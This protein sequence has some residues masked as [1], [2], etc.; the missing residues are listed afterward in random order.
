MTVVTVKL[1]DAIQL[2][3]ENDN[4][5]K[6]E[7]EKELNIYKHSASMPLC[8]EQYIIK[9][10]AEGKSYRDISKKTGYALATV[11]RKVRQYKSKGMIKCNLRPGCRPFIK[12]PELLIA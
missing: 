2:A 1:K 12:I 5:K 10:F 11:G 9:L 7:L 4:L 8:D 3:L 6:R